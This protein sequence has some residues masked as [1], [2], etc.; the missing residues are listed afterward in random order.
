MGRLI[1]AGLGHFCWENPLDIEG[2]ND[3]Y[4]VGDLVAENSRY[5]VR[6]CTNSDGRE[7][8]LQVAVDD[9]HNGDVA[10]NAFLLSQLK[11]VADATQKRYEESERTGSL[12]YD[13]GFPELCDNFVLESQGGRQVNILGF[14]Y[15]DEVSSVIPLVKFWKSSLRV[16]L[17]TSAWIMGKLLKVVSFAHDNRMEV[18]R[19]S[20]NNVLIEPDKHYTLVFDWS[21]VVIH[22]EA[23]PASVRRRE[24]QASA[25]TV[26]KALGGDL[27]RARA[28]DADLPYTNHLQ[29]LSTTGESDATEAHRAFYEIVDSLCEDPESV[30]EKG[31]HEFTTHAL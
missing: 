17:R 31:F 22:E 5:R 14:R 29:L 16:D 1:R 18:S 19:I 30:W 28:N 13:L 27:D 25:Q 2:N 9:S 7:L 11:S 8:L 23:V 3:S 21:N 10:K 6:K 4:T 12:S 20:G 24:I 26:I 15:V